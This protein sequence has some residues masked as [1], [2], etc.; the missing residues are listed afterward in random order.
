M[1]RNSILLLL[2]L[3]CLHNV[4][5]YT[6]KVRKMAETPFHIFGKIASKI[7]NS[8]SS[9]DSIDLSRFLHTS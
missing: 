3:V 5:I 9:V 7:E 4:Q 1:W 8:M 6:S 2:I